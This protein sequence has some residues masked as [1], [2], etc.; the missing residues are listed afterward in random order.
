M[1]TSSNKNILDLPVEILCLILNFENLLPHE[2]SGFLCASRYA[3]EVANHNQELGRFC[4]DG[5]G[6]RTSRRSL[7]GDWIRAFRR[8]D[9]ST[10]EA[11]EGTKGILACPDIVNPV[12][13]DMASLLSVTFAALNMARRGEQFW[14]E[15]YVEESLRIAH[16]AKLSPPNVA[17]I[18]HIMMTTELH[19]ARIS[20]KRSDKI[21]MCLHLRRA[22]QLAQKGDFALPDV[23]PI[24]QFM[25]GPCVIRSKE[26]NKQSSRI[27]PLI[28][29]RLNMISY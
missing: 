12:P 27:W 5:Q 8:C 13:K 25:F 28:Y 19:R 29:P 24:W 22:S 7:M 14:A 16:D 15:T 26:G 4:T 18:L 23:R 9:I 20:A 10:R 1:A 3:F 11:I 21:L 6:G 17:P 2:Q